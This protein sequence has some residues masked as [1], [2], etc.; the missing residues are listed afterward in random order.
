MTQDIQ[1]AKD[2]QAVD[3]M[4]AGLQ[5][6]M[7]DGVQQ[8]RAAII[9]SNAGITEHV[10]W[11]AP[12]FCFAGEDRVTFRMH[13]KGLL[14]LVFH[15]GAKVRADSAEFVFE[16]GTGLLEWATTDRAVVTLKDQADVDAHQSELVALIN[17]W[18]L[19]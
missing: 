7:K 19:A 5:H 12:S 15:R 3:A 14:Q 13:P 8:L 6:P 16:D 11:K 18:V 1:S 9:G 2:T 10:K 4:I 17:R